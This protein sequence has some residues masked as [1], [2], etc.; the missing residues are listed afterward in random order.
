MA[1]TAQV[2]FSSSLVKVSDCTCDTPKSG[3]GRER[4]DPLSSITIARRGVH[5]YHALGQ[6]A[7]AETGIALLYRGGEPYCLSHPYD[8]EHPDRSTCVEFDAALLDEMF[9]DND[10]ARGPGT[11]ISPRT[12]L[13]N[14]QVIRALRSDASD[15]LAAEEMALT[16]LRAVASDFD[17]GRND[18]RAPA[19]IRQRIERA[20]AFIATQPDANH[21]LEEVA[22]AAACSPFH[23][24][25]LFKRHTGMTLRGYRLRLRLATVLDL[26]ADGATD[27]TALALH[28]GFSDHSHMTTSFRR[29]FGS[30][31]SRLRD[32]LRAADLKEHSK[33]LQARL[34]VRT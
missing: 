3:R 26:L 27:L 22:A 32:T 21:G 19:R 33:F 11:L 14:F 29:I 31:P 15:R 18:P 16:L 7:L 24:A 13:F 2:L 9:G 34:R 28:V 12:Q 20:R 5:A 23:L 17:L 10:P 25:R 6:T 30:T 1:S 8:R 4:S